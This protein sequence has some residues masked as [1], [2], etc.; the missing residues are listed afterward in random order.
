[1]EMELK[2]VCKDLRNKLEGRSLSVPRKGDLIEDEDG[3]KYRVREVIY[4]KRGGQF[5]VL[6]ES[7]LES[8]PQDT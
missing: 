4:K 7:D 8:A 6:L 3:Q 5:E 2:V 1:M